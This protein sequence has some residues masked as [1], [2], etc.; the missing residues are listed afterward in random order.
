MVLTEAS[1]LLNQTQMKP[2]ICAVLR[3]SG[4]LE[5]VFQLLWVRVRSDGTKS[6]PGT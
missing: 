5:L 4:V 1:L 3:E 6:K 2:C